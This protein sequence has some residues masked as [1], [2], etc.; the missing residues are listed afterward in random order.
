MIKIIFTSICLCLL[1][2][3]LL[4][5]TNYTQYVDPFIGT[6]GHGHTYP[7]ASLPH[8]MVQLS[9]DGGTTGWD[10]CSG[11]HYSDS[12]IIGFSHTHLSGTGCA[13]Y[14]DILFMPT[15]GEVKTE[16]GTKDDPDSGYRSRFNHKNETASPGYY[17]VLLDDYN[18]E[19]ELT[20]TKRAGFHRYTFPETDK[21][22]IVI[23]LDHGIG[24][25]VLDAKLE[26]I[27]G[28]TIA[29]YRRSKGWANNHCVYFYAEFSQPFT[30]YGIVEN[31]EDHAK[32][33]EAQ[34]KNIK[35]YIQ[36]ENS[37]K[38]T[39]L[40]KVGISHTSL[41][42]AKKNLAKEI[43]GWDFDEIKKQA[44]NEWQKELSAIDVNSIDETNKRIFYTALYHALLNPNVFSDVDGNYIGMDG[45]IHE[46]QGRDM[47]TVFSLWDTFRAE[48]PLFTILNPQRAGDMVQAL[49]AKYEESGLLP[50]WELASNETGTM[51]GYHSIPVIVDAY[52]KGIRNYD[53]EKAYE[54]MI[55]SAMQDHLG[56]KYYMEMG[57]IPSD[58]ENESVSKMLEYAYDDWC[59][60]KMAQ[61]LGREEDYNYFIE[62]AK[63]YVNAFDPATSLMRPKR[64][65]KWYEPFD[66]YSVSG[67][68][69]EANA[70]QYSFFVPQ[71]VNGIIELIGGDNKFVTML[72]E[73]FNAPTTLSGREQPDISGLIG[74]YAHGNEPSHH[75]AYLYNYAGQSWKTQKRVREILTTLYNDEPD[76]LP[77][78]EDCG[79][80]S[81][82]YVLSA[83]GFY[84]VTP[85]DNNYIIGTPLFDEATIKIADRE[86]KIIANNLSPTNIYI[87][88][89]T[90]NNKEYLKSYI[91]HEDIVNGGTL[92]FNMGSK[93]SN[94][95]KN[96]EDRPVAV[97]NKPFLPIPYATSGERVFKDS[98][99][100]ALASIRH[101][102]DIFYSS[103][104]SDPKEKRKLYSSPLLISKTSVIKA[105]CHKNGVFSKVLTMRFN[106]VLKERSII[107]TRQPHPK[108][109]GGGALALIDNITGTD[110]FHTES[111]QGY[112]GVDFE[113]VVDLGEIQNLES[114]NTRFLQDIRSWIFFPK[115]IIYSISKNGEKYNKVYE[116]SVVTDEDN[117]PTEIRTFE[118]NLYNK[119]ARYI[120]VFAESFGPC[121]DWHFAPGGKTWIFIDE[122]A[123]K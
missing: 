87:Q 80:M 53:V 50:V 43:P 25:I 77:G 101:P 85:G 60:A 103:D 107:L 63:F 100:V 96:L 110:N 72:D 28:K 54:A 6:D 10:W 104:G 115:K 68:Y 26:I 90:L 32:K 17:S 18:I 58:L 113:A 116:T 121:P 1:S 82:W 8:G 111:W 123:V 48:H 52:F 84:P 108:Y 70:W 89:L 66:P 102:I 40:G 14:G 47:Y 3:R 71:D 73:L 46:V 64:N 69:T 13:D 49:I 97:I 30:N 29:G 19:A 75:M 81:A 78:N 36:F 65:G 11:Y 42:G 4:A 59:I 106:K 99:V 114:I 27:D 112:E 117:Q 88:S 67:N 44:E 23:D 83:L 22:N 15:T 12:S 41:E 74:Q 93:S 98:T 24:E 55:K 34:C 16:P 119:N 33:V 122:I 91:L 37:S 5:Q 79:Q 56:L 86:F 31:G 105:V 57:Y 9:P 45:K 2:V 51:I 62:R 21:A 120:K 109:T 92:T 38:Q 61:D 95:G 94:F 76:G 118:C 20:V 35:A 39:V 7:G